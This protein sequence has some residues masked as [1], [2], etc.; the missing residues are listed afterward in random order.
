MTE[1]STKAT[2]PAIAEMLNCDF[3]RVCP[4]DAAAVINT[5]DTL[6]AERDRLKARNEA[7]ESLLVCYRVGKRPTEALLKKLDQTRAA[8]ALKEGEGDE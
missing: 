2:P 3:C 1:S 8:T 6:L 7:L 5:H 4:D